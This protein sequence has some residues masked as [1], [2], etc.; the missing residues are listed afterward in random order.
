M[1]G[2]RWQETVPLEV[3]VFAS[4]LLQNSACCV[5]EE[6]EGWTGLVPV[7]LHLKSLED[8]LH[9]VVSA[10]QLALVTVG[11]QKHKTRFVVVHKGDLCCNTRA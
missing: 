10:V 9:S 5:S 2:S 11:L 1:V 3:S 6:R 4:V 8:C 7:T